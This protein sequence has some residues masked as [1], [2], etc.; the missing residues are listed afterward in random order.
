MIG[1][2]GGNPASPVLHCISWTHC[3]NHTP[4]NNWW[5]RFHCSRPS[6]VQQPKT[7]LFALGFN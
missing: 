5:Q 7:H 2:G 3:T 1:R 4:F 6:A